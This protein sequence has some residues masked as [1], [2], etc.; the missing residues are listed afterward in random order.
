VEVS[1]PIILLASSMPNMFRY[2]SQRYQ[3]RLVSYRIRAK[4]THQICIPH[5]SCARHPLPI[6]H[7]RS[8]FPGHSPAELYSPS[9]TTHHNYP[10]CHVPSERHPTCNRPR[11]N[12][13]PSRVFFPLVSLSRSYLGSTKMTGRWEAILEK[14]T[15]GKKKWERQLWISEAIGAGKGGGA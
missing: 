7:R 4:S 9:K 10:R 11:C 12:S 6:T 13:K 1:L 15:R 14:R 8:H 3:P 5:V 2:D